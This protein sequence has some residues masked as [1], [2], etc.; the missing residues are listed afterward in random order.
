MLKIYKAQTCVSLNVYLPTGKNLHVSFMP[1]SNGTSSYST[2][3]EVIQE[4]L[5]SHHQFGKL[6][7]LSQVVDE[8]A[9]VVVEAKKE[10]PKELLQVEVSDLSDAKC[11]IA[12]KFGVSRT[13]LRTKAAIVEHGLLHGVEFVGI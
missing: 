13:L 4:G 6:F 11:Y 2:S 3:N 1:H 9:P 12:D 7:N 8:T 10:A 5:E